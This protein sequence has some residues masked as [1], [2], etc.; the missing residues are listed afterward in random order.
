[1]TE[2]IINARSLICTA[3]QINDKVAS[4]QPIKMK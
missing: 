4:S 3:V 1:M 2:K